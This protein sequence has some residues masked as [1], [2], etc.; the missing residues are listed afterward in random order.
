MSIK[1]KE[2]NDGIFIN[3]DSTS[4]LVLEFVKEYLGEDQTVP[5]ILTDPP[6]GNIVKEK[7]DRITTTDIKFCEWMVDWTHKWRQVLCTGGAFYV[8][9]GLGIPGFRPFTRYLHEAERHDFQLANI[10]TWSKKRAYG[11]QNNYLYTREELAYFVNGNAKK[12]KTF[13][14]PLLETK[15]G[16]SGYN[17]NYP[18]KSEFYRR[19]NVWTDVNEIFSGKKHPTQ[20]PQRVLEIPIEVHTHPGEYVLDLF[21][22]SGSTGLTARALGRKFVLVEKDAETYEKACDSFG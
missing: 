18:A 12:P 22:G 9:G 8:W 3:G 6:Y 17:E 14:I 5:L 1:H 7:W 13:N 15:R 11:V 19:T 20:K 2:Y 10:I 16:Y 4:D 21:A